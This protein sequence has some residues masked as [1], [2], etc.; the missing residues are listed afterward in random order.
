MLFEEPGESRKKE[1][2]IILVMKE[3]NQKGP[4]ILTDRRVLKAEGHSYMLPCRN[5]EAITR[6]HL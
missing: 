1:E 4:F 2:K 5:R 6:A 3:K